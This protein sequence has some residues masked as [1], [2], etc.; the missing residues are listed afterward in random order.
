MDFESVEQAGWQCIECTFINGDYDPVCSMC[1]VPRPT[2]DFDWFCN[3]CKSRNHYSLEKCAICAEPAIKAANASSVNL[4]KEIRVPVID[5][6]HQNKNCSKCG[7]ANP[8]NIKNCTICFT[9]INVRGEENPQSMTPN[10]DEASL[11]L[12]EILEQKPLYLLEFTKDFLA[13]TEKIIQ[14]E[15]PLRYRF[16]RA[17][18]FGDY[19]ETQIGQKCGAHSI[20]NLFGKQIVCSKKTPSSNVV[21]GLVELPINMENVKNNNKYFGSKYKRSEQSGFTNY[22]HADLKLALQMIGYNLGGYE[23]T[24]RTNDN[25]FVDCVGRSY[26]K[27]NVAGW[28]C[29]TGGHW[30]AVRYQLLANGAEVFLNVN[31]TNNGGPRKINGISNVPKGY[32]VYYEYVFSIEKFNNN[33]DDEFWTGWFIPWVKKQGYSHYQ[34]QSQKKL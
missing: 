31:S 17:I 20:N 29:Y 24:W 6:G 33:D 28:I 3:E 9:V 1:Y 15:V 30:F 22:S 16:R 14:V 18:K 26:H 21:E 32:I 8:E 5:Y 4:P 23:S 19:F 34:E 27:S 7:W 13:K 25:D 2:T 11:L 10:K 12:R